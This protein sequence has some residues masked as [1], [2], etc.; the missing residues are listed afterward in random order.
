ML[1]LSHFSAKSIKYFKVLMY[2]WGG[3][4]KVIDI[5]SRVVKVT[6]DMPISSVAETMDNQHTES[7]L[8][9][10]KNKAI[11]I[12]TEKDLLR[13]VV[14]LC[15]NPLVVTARDIMTAPLYTISPDASIEEASHLMEKHK[16]RRL[17]IKDSR[18]IYGKV[19]AT[20][21]AKNVRYLTGKRLIEI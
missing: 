10:E 17:I 13:K 4:M 14:K 2:F 1:H 11:G 9:E 8:V 3:S 20:D 7:V 19:T 16:V 15:K 5:S 21:I 6:P 12:I 18:K